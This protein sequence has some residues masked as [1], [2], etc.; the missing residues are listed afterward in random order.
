MSETSRRR[1][2]SRQTP[3]ARRT[4]YLRIGE[5]SVLDGVRLDAIKIDESSG[6]G[7]VPPGPFGALDSDAVARRLGKTRGAINHVFGSQAAYRAATWIA[8]D[9]TLDMGGIEAATY[10]DPSSAHDLASWITKVAQVEHARGPH[11]TKRPDGYA[12]RWLLWTASLPY[13]L[14]S[15]YLADMSQLEFANW[16]REIEQRLVSPALSH[17]DLAVNP[18]WTT[19]DLAL[20]HA[21]L[22]EGLWMTQ[23]LVRKHKAPWLRRT[24]ESAAVNALLMLWTGATTT[25]R[26]TDDGT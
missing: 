4:D 16:V 9:E 12:R 15:R 11:H 13:G 23:V 22:V 21:N 18:P 5:E 1:T 26:V 24:T 10:P 20:A 14:W 2:R 25:R 6:T 7:H 3:E 8:V 17:F 19:T